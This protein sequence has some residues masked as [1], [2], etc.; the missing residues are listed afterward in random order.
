LILRNFLISISTRY[1]KDWRLIAK[2]AYTML[3]ALVNEA[4]MHLD[5]TTMGPLLIK[6][7][8]ATVIGADMTPVLTYRNGQKEVYLPGSSLKGVFRSHIEKVVNSIK[9][10]VACDPLSQSNDA[11]GDS[12]QIRKGDA[13][14]LYRPSCSHE[15]LGEEDPPSHQI[16]AKL[17]P[18]C[19]LFGSTTFIGRITIDDAYLPF[20][21]SGAQ[22]LVEHRDGVALDRLTG[23]ASGSAKFDLNVVPVGI[24]FST[25]VRLRNFEIW[26]LGMLFVIIQDMEDELIRI[27]S[28]RSRGLGKIKAVISEKQ[29]GSHAGGVR[30]STIRTGKQKEQDTE[31]WGLGCWIHDEIDDEIMYGTKGDDKLS[32]SQPVPHISRGIRNV[33]TLKGEVLKDVK[34]RSIEYF[35]TSM[36][37]WRTTSEETTTGT[38]Q[39]REK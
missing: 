35:V 2:G 39:R 21:S 25:T 30:L 33:R 6:S 34:E 11:R 38:Q 28:G 31:L 12:A 24:T 37:Q 13:R 26:Q 29:E 3:K 27:G 20:G 36:Q 22:E 16:Y 18:T 4:Y 14:Q 7:G 10:R 15:N 17:C 8:Y 23:G 1:L 19:R 9:S 5:I 32:L